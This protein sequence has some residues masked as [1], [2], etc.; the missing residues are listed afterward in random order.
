MRL[1]GAEDRKQPISGQLRDRAAKAVDL[2]AHEAHNLVEE[3]LR[4][5]RPEALSDPGRICDVGDQDGDVTTFAGGILHG[6][7]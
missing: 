2:L 4:P 7:A 1:G 5:L 3:E 6:G